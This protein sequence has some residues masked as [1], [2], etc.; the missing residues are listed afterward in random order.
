[1]ATDRGRGGNQSDELAV[2]PEETAALRSDRL[3]R[4]GHSRTRRFWRRSI[5]RHRVGGACAVVGQFYGQQQVGF[6]GSP[7]IANAE[8]DRLR[9]AEQVS[10][11]FLVA[12]G[13]LGDRAGITAE[14]EEAPALLIE[15]DE[16][17][18]GIVLDDGGAVLEDEV[19]HR[20]E[21]A[22]MQEVGRALEQAVAGR[23]R[24]TEL[25]EAA[26]LDAGIGKIGREI[27]QR[28]FHAIAAGE[29]DARTAHRVRT[30]IFVTEI[31]R[32]LSS[33]AIGRDAADGLARARQEH[34][35]D[36]QRAADLAGMQINLHLLGDEEGEVQDRRDR[37]LDVVERSA[38]AAARQ[39]R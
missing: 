24:G 37:T 10:V 28:L 16:R 8:I 39:L 3:R 33:S 26:R 18:A 12:A 17:D 6:M 20:G 1:M 2:E 29:D 4:P 32:A 30:G 34:I 25:Q 22:G 27:I 23:Q 21:V 5:R 9:A 31:G 13:E 7:A 15:V 35:E 11:G 19:A 14:R 38:D 36:R